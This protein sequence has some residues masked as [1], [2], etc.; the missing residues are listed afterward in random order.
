M[1]E[2]MAMSFNKPV[3]MT[4][5]FTG[6]V[7]RGDYN[8]DGWGLAFYPDSSKA[9]QVIKEPVRAGVS[10]MTGFLKNYRHIRS[11]LYI[12]HVRWATSKV[13]YANTHP[14]MR[15]LGGKEYTFAHNGYLL[16]FETALPLERFAPMG[17]TDSEHAFC[18]LLDFIAKQVDIWDDRAFSKI[19]E[20]MREVNKLGNFNCLFTDGQYLFCYRDKNGYKGLSYTLRQA[21]F[22]HVKLEDEDFEIDLDSMKS[23]D[24]K[25]CIIATIPLTR[26]EEWMPLTPGHLTVFHKGEKV[27]PVRNEVSDEEIMLALRCIRMAP[28]RVDVFSIGNTVG[29]KLNNIAPLIDELK[30][31]GYI[32]QDSRDTE[33]PYSPV[34]TYY[35][36]PSKR[37][38]IDALLEEDKR[39]SLG[40]LS[41]LNCLTAL[42]DDRTLMC[43]NC[44][45]VYKNGAGY[46]RN[47]LR[48]VQ[49]IDTRLVGI[50]Y[51]LNRKG[52]PTAFSCGGHANN[53]FDIYIQCN[54][55]I[56]I[57]PPQN[58]SSKISDGTTVL[59]SLPY[60]KV[61]GI[62]T[63]K[64][65]ESINS[66][67]IEA[68]S[69][70]NLEKLWS[71]VELLPTKR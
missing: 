54:C 8:R 4:F 47:C 18:Y 30:G 44:L 6:M 26:G 17:T 16:G 35:T 5:S 27:F 56:D 20:V 25:G 48:D 14:F 31:R 10:P 51:E 53:N 28:N 9:A 50:L 46:C 49:V 64:A 52:Y 38:E 66:D 61:K 58:Y 55:Q 12:S 22:G 60:H 71:W 42:P 67:E 41:D 36:V 59:R 7:H 1:C 34:S 21:P 45:L 65:R 33:G 43:M 32:K 68:F 62:T 2:L 37:Q 40:S 24:E 63:K 70:Q 29:R 11:S 57:E 19:E 69:K 3:N 13:S 39:K 15:E 23:P